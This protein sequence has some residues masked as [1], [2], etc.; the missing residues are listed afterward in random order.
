MVWSSSTDLLLDL[1]MTPTLPLDL[2]PCV[3]VVKTPVVARSGEAARLAQAGEASARQLAAAAQTHEQT[4]A[5]VLAAL[6]ER[7]IACRQVQV[8]A[9]GAPARRAIAAARLVVSV[10][11]DGTLLTASHWVRDG[12]LLAVN[13]APADSVGFFSLATLETFAAILDRIRRG[14]M[15][16]LAVA[17]LAVTLDGQQLPEPALNDVLAVHQHP[18]A[19]SRYCLQLGKREEEHRSSGLWIAGPAG[20]TAGI[21]SAGGRRTPLLSRRLQFRAR[22]LYRAPGRTY[23]L[24]SGFV[25]PGETLVVESRMENGWLFLD[26]ARTSYRFPFGARAEV[27]VAPSPLHLFADPA[28]WAGLRRS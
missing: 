6:A 18:A 10:G 13:S 26:G 20:S 15:R 21:A 4:L 28:R 27:R 5:A 24:A 8:E 16:P 17:R 9:L 22:E 11:G 12:L 7:G 25:P 14:E 2:S 3:V 1:S 23:G 19:T